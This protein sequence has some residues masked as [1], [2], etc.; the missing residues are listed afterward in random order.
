[1][2]YRQEIKILAAKRLPSQFPFPQKKSQY[3]SEPVCRKER[4]CKE[5]PPRCRQDRKIC[6]YTQEWYLLPEVRQSL[7]APEREYFKHF[8]EW[9]ELRQ[10]DE[11]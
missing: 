4:G 1:M 9:F 2:S 5:F 7:P 8:L 3:P 6:P 11:L 10:Q